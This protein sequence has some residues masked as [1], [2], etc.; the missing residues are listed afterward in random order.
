MFVRLVLCGAEG[1]EEGVLKGPDWRLRVPVTKTLQRCREAGRQ[2]MA[3]WGRQ[4]LDP[5][6]DHY[7]QSLTP[8]YTSP[9]AS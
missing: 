4:L 9:L 8:C 5:S 7:L 6:F 1:Q 3:R 2:V